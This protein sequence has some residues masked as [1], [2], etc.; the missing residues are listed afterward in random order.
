MNISFNITNIL[1]EQFI[2]ASRWKL[3]EFEMND[4]RIVKRNLKKYIGSCIDEYNKCMILNESSSMVL[5]LEEQA[6][7][8][9]R[10]C[11]LANEEYA[12]ARSLLESTYTPVDVDPD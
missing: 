8:L 10:Q 7:S 2:S 12:K 3:N 11:L 9:R 4:D 1:G 6:E 5:S